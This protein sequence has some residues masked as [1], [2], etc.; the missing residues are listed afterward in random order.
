MNGSLLQIC[1]HG[2]TGKHRGFAFVEFEDMEDATAAHDNFNGA[3]LFGKTLTVNLARA[4]GATSR[5]GAFALIIVSLC[6]NIC[7][8]ASV[9]HKRARERR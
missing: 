8:S 4:A 2:R 6:C 1:L 9:G 7:G 5:A 3:E